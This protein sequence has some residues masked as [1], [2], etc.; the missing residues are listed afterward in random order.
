MGFTP[1][2]G[3]IMGT[4]PGDI[5]AGVV[6]RLMAK[7]ELSIGETETLLN[8]RSG[9][10]G[11]SGISD[12]FREILAARAKG[13]ERAVL[14]VDAFC[15]RLKKYLGAYAAILGKVDAVVF[16]GGIGEHIPEI[17]S[18]AIEGLQGWGIKLDEGANQEVSGKEACLSHSDSSASIW[19]VPADEELI[20][21]RDTVRC[22][23]DASMFA[24]SE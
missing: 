12:D 19:V 13:N 22:V 7:E 8:R 24:E 6:L 15:H 5:D 4:R 9:L 18:R 11:L 3:L 2:E 16:T 20:I 1:C 17:R 14:A 10:L 23:E 21:A